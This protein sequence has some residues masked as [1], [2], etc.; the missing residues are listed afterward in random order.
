MCMKSLFVYHIFQINEDKVN[1][2]FTNV[3]LKK[4]H[5][6]LKCWTKYIGHSS[7]SFENGELTVLLGVNCIWKIVVEYMY[8]DTKSIHCI[9]LTFFLW[10]VESKLL[11]FLLLLLKIGI[12][13]IFF[14]KGNAFKYTLSLTKMHRIQVQLQYC[15]ALKFRFI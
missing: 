4:I 2:L 1:L 5:D 12:C 10:Y 6:R 15:L 3:L 13:Y 8:Q 9:K 7:W 14:K 11:I